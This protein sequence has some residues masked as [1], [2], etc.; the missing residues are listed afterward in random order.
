MP[1]PNN[2]KPNDSSDTVTDHER[3]ERLESELELTSEVL[4]RLG[5]MITMLSSTIANAKV[6]VNLIRNE[7]KR[8]L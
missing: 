5:K 3:L 8:P 7:Y 6:E 2:S 1:A 4:E